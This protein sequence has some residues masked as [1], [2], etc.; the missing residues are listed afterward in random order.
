MALAAA[1]CIGASHSASAHDGPPYPIVSD[2][3][4]GPYVIS[5]WT[6]PDT[7]DDGTAG[8]QFWVT[9]GPDR[10]GAQPRDVHVTIAATP[11]RGGAP[12]SVD[13]VANDTG[14]H[15]GALVLY[16]EGRFRIDVRVRGPRGDAD[17]T[18][19]V[20]ATYD[21]RPPPFVVVLYAVPFVLAGALWVRLL[22]RRR[23]GHD[24]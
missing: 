2:R 12:R 4:A 16:H 10:S 18:A 9:F 6:D 14:S 11:A 21:L 20:D 19:A 7:T 17:V 24:A 3:T 23:G 8:G 5:V 15:F 13:A 1:L 22:M